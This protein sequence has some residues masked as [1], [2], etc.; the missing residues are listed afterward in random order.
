[1]ANL[2]SALCAD[3]SLWID[4]LPDHIALDNAMG[5][6]SNTDARGAKAAMTQL[7]YHSPVALAFQLDADLDHIY[8]GHSP[9]IFPADPLHP[10]PFDNLCVLILGDDITNANPICLRAEACRNTATP[11][12][13]CHNV[14]TLVA[15]HAAAPPVTSCGWRRRH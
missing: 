2:A 3:A 15:G 14:P 4:P 6:P 9:S 10:T 1:M 11:G 7:A 12:I 8:V 5:G 13:L